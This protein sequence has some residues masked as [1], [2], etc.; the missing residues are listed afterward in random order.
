MKVFRIIAIMSL[1][2]IVG[3]ASSSPESKP[4]PTYTPYPPQEPLPTYTPYP[5][6]E[7]LPTYAPYPTYTPYPEP[8]EPAAPKAEPAPESVGL[9]E[10]L[11]QGDYTF[12]ATQ[13]EDPATKP[14]YF[15]EAEEGMRLVAVEIIVGNVS[16]DEVSSNPLYSVLVDTEGFT[17][18][19]ELAGVEG[20]I[21]TLNLS[22]GEKSKGWV[23]FIIPNDAAPA[24]IKYEFEM[25]PSLYLAVSLVE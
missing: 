16:A 15:Y 17:Y 8:V 22:P 3:C 24:T 12:G 11:T 9:G 10:M 19:P 18:Q 20:Q 13:L 2:L 21:E 23:G 14:G 1:L 4:L 7:P 25:F 5:T 6:L